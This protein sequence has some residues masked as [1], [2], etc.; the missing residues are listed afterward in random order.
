MYFLSFNFLFFR[1]HFRMSPTEFSNYIKQRA[2]QQQMHHH[3]HHGHHQSGAQTSPTGRSISPN[4]LGAQHQST[5]PAPYFFHQPYQFP[6]HRNMFE[7]SN[8]FLS[9]DLYP[10]ASKYQPFD[11]QFGF[12]TGNATNNAGVVQQQQNSSGNQNDNGKLLD[13]LNASFA[14]LGS[15]GPYPASQYQHLLVAN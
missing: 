10:Q 13:G 15:V 2:M 4:Q 6:P 7:S 9:A 3:H 12:P 5:D 8:Q 14:G 11:H 1:F